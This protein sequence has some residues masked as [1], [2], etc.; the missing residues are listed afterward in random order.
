M[1]S[2]TNW[3]E[4]YQAGDTPWDKGTVH[5]ALPGWLRSEPWTGKILV[6]GCGSGHDVRALAG[7]GAEVIGLDLAPS[8]IAAAE[9]FARGGNE[10]YVEGDLFDL[11]L[12]WEETFD[13]VF[14]H[15]CFC[16]IAPGKRPDYAAAITKVL[17]PGGQLRAIFYLNP[18]HDE[19][20][21]PYGCTRMELNS[22]FASAF[23]PVSETTN[24]PTFP[25]RE[26]RECGM[27]WRKKA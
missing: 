4:R 11:P 7:S 22:L 13:G 14:E 27:I 25:G 6:P 23:D 1:G 8:A 16:A 20:G 10:S 5:P 3:E 18:D 26:G 12:E 15:T 24:F 2:A 17:K 19:E 21:P 9:R